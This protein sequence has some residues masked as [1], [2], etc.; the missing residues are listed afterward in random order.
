TVTFAITFP[1][2]FG[3]MVADVGYGA[4]TLLIAVWLMRVGEGKMSAKI[5]PK[6][7]RAFGR[8]LMP[9]RVFATLGRILIPASLVAI[10]FG[11]AFNEWLGF[12]LGYKALLDIIPSVPILL[13]AVVFI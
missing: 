13:A 2:F 4:I 8:G 12:A 5:M 11:V 7:I 1:L 6:P 9:K 3:L 10:A